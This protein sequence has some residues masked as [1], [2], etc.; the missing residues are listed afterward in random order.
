MFIGFIGY[1]LCELILGAYG[2]YFYN[3]Y[4]GTHFEKSPSPECDNIKYLVKTLCVIDLL[5]A[6]TVSPTLFAF[7]DNDTPC[8]Y[9]S[10][11]LAFIIFIGMFTIPSI[12]CT[13]SVTTG[14]GCTFDTT[15]NIYGDQFNVTT[16]YDYWDAYNPTIINWIKAHLYVYAFTACVILIT[17]A[18][19]ILSLCVKKNNNQNTNTNHQNGYNAI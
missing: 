17:C 3:K 1:I 9:I 15:C 4:D 12:F 2:I 13:C 10:P 14:T 7:C 16:C 18:N 6:V 5:T 8:Y 11:A 19:I